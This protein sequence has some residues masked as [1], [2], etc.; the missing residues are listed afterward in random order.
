MLARKW[1][2]TGISAKT[3]LVGGGVV[4][5]LLAI[6]LIYVV[7][8]EKAAIGFIIGEYS[9]GVMA[10]IDK[11]GKAQ[12]EGQ[13]ETFAATTVLVGGVSGPFLYNLAEEELK[14]A[15]TPFMNIPGII[16]IKV[17]DEQGKPFVAVW[18]T[19][20]VQTARQLPEDLKVDEGFCNSVES[21][22][23]GQKVGH[24]SVY[25][26]M[27]LLE[28]QLQESKTQE[29]AKISQFEEAINARLAG[30]I[31]KQ[32]LAA[33][34]V[35]F[36]LVVTI[37]MCL[38]AFAV[39]P[40]NKVVASLHDIAE[41]EGDLTARLPVRGQDE[42]GRLAERFNTFMEKL[43]GIVRQ[44]M[45]NTEL[46]KTS[47][48]RL[49]EVAGSMAKAME[50]MTSQTDGLAQNADQVQ[51]NMDEVACSTEQL[52]ASVNT[53]A[54][55]V[56]E[57][58]A[59]VAEIAQNAGSSAHI[60]AK[61]AT[62][63]ANTGQVVQRL[64][65]SAQEIGKVVEVI[66]DIAEQTKLLALN[67]TIEAAR[68]GE[69][70]KGFAVVAGEVKE[71][72]SQTAR[73]TEDIRAKIKDIQGNT[74]GAVEAI[75]QIG[76]VIRQVNEMAQNIAASVEQQS[77][78]TNEIAQNV[79]QAATASNGV[80]RTTG[81]TAA[82]S[83][84]MAQAVGDV[85]SVTQGTAQNAAKVRRAALELSQLSENLQGLVNQFRV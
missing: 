51:G 17:L 46:L 21:L 47:S 11:Q 55:A 69:S 71:L 15:L 36:F 5:L 72:A 65:E 27:T 41:G 1:H 9:K 73:S 59:S 57:V 42:V 23:E 83:R 22:A 16:A 50:E 84:E 45:A 31:T 79:A 75:D 13:Q 82:V 61:A 80:S 37:F 24:V 14:R 10:T 8:S 44:V 81:Q 40:I 6:L 32:S 26:D 18:K 67:A 54:S 48:S 3:S 49:E 4:F 28:R 74:A 39:T 60:A 2:S 20:K 78:T 43:Q 77:A 66:V 34:G 12:R 63:T 62:I 35:I 85:S 30:E 52:S 70:G 7:N 68:A 33:L 38:R 25:Y 56:E 64:K 53:M 58:T 76:E 29:T 19:G